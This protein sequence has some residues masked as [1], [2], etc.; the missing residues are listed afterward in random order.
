MTVRLK[1]QPK[2]LSRCALKLFKYVVQKIMPRLKLHAHNFSK[3]ILAFKS[4]HKRK[5]LWS[6]FNTILYKSNSRK[7]IGM[8]KIAAKQHF[9]ISQ[10][11]PQKVKSKFT[12]HNYPQVLSCRRK[13]LFARPVDEINSQS[14]EDA[15]G[16]L[17][18]KKFGPGKLWVEK[19]W[20]FFLPLWPI[21][22]LNW[23]IHFFTL[24]PD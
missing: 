22:S 17:G 24:P 2:N 8:P 1:L 12:G 7:I 4:R 6:V 9:N 3:V 21:F 15:S 10:V 11:M 18:L 5:H 14:L 13:L 20:A 23:T 19:V 16:T